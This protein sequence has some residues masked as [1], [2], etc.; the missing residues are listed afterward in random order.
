LALDIGT[1]RLVGNE[2][3]VE[4]GADLILL[5]VDVDEGQPG[6]VL[7]R[8]NAEGIVRGTLDT[9]GGPLT[10]L[11]L[12]GVVVPSADVVTGPLIEPA[13]ARIHA[14]Q[15]LLICAELCGLASGAL[16]MTADYTGARQQF[17]RPIGTFQAVSNRLGDGY[18]DVESMTWSMLR[19]ADSHDRI[20]APDGALAVARV[21]A[22]EGADRTLATAQHLH[23]G[24]GV[25]IDYPLHRLYLRT[26]QLLVRLGGTERSLAALG[27]LIAAGVS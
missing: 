20:G 5:W 15:M 22:C 7:L 17:G 23:G 25:D 21:W 6:F 16:R 1:G 27:D 26:R 18:I 14:L 13:R 19:A 10:A 8:P 9:A 3:I 24:L 2:V 4:P 12:D 11:H